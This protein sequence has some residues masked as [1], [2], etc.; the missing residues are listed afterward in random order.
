MSLA[1]LIGL[2]GLI[3]AKPGTNQPPSLQRG[4]RERT[5]S[6]LNPLGRSCLLICENVEGYRPPQRASCASSLSRVGVPFSL[7]LLL[8]LTPSSLLMKYPLSANHSKN[9]HVP[10][11]CH[12][13]SFWFLRTRVYLSQLVTHWAN[14]YWA[15]ALH[16]DL[17]PARRM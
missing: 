3:E 7:L 17:F 6:G 1:A 10:V 11:V 12:S 2:Y 5:E 13:N 16:Q 8:P 4:P 14:V 15:S 9:A